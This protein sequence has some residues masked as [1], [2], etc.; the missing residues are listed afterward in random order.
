[1]A[2]KNNKALMATW[3]LTK[4]LVST[5]LRPYKSTVAGAAVFMAVAAAMT[6]AMAYLMESII[7]DVFTAK[8]VSQL[9]PVALMVFGSFFFRGIATYGHTVMMSK[10]GQRIIADVQN[11]MFSTLLKADLSFFHERSSG[12]LMSRMISDANIMRAAVS[13]SLTSMGKSVL[14]L[15]VLMGVMFY[16]DWKLTII[17]LFVFPMAAFFVA[18][19]GKKLRRVATDAQEQTAQFSGLLGQVFQGIRHV[20]SYGMEG[21]EE[22]RIGHSVESIYRLMYKAFRVS[23]LATPMSEILSGAAIVTIIVYG[24]YQVMEGVSTAGKLFSFITAFLLAYEPMKRIAKLNNTFQIGLAAAERVFFILDNKPSIRNKYKAKKLKLKKATLLLENMNFTYPDGTQALR[25]VSLVI[26]AGKTVALV[27][28]SGS[29]KSTILNLIPRFYDL[30]TGSILINGIDIRDVTL[31][32][33]RGHMALV[34]QEIAIFD[35]PIK[36]NIAYGSKNASDKDI[37]KAAKMAAA[38]DFIMELPEQYN[39]CG[40]EHGVKLSGGQRQRIAIARAMLRNAPILLLDEATSALDT[41]S[42][43]LVQAALEKL[44]KGKTT[45]IVAHRLS[46]I[47][48][49]DLIYVM[50]RGQIVEQGTHKELLKKKGFYADLYSHNFQRT[51]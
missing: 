23:A 9:W 41:Q 47:M 27:G 1:M 35:D 16:Q 14:T 42:E 43:R 4:R 10:V 24:G 32:S 34:S 39:T 44:Q 6:G 5:Y 31:K 20:K 3:P 40:G 19:L 49:A 7:D 50:D 15:M 51:A 25:D 11:D 21:A 48:N 37:I 36:D 26:P 13:D 38:H 29:G 8:N 18:R 17:T 30:D 28:A 33:L 46:T 12:E 45:L 22:Q 2:D